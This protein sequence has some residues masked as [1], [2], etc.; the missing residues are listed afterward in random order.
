MCKLSDSFAGSVALSFSL[1]MGVYACSLALSTKKRHDPPD[2]VEST[3]TAEPVQVVEKKRNATPVNHSEPPKLI[4]RPTPKSMPSNVKNTVTEGAGL[5]AINCAPCHQADGAGLPGFAPS[6][7]NRDF[8]ALS[9]DALILE[10]VRKGRLGTAMAPRP[11][12][13]EETVRKIIAYMRSMTV[14]NAI[15]VKVDDSLKFSG[16]AEAGSEKYARYCSSCHGPAGEGYSVGVP[17]TGIGLPG[18]LQAVSD[19][20]ILQTLKLGRI[21]TPMQP[22]V[23]SRGLANLSVSDAHDIIAHLREL[24]KRNSPGATDPVSEKGDPARGKLSY[25]V[26]CMACHQSEGAGRV[27][28]AP[29]IRNRDFLAIATDDF[30]RTTIKKG[31]FGTA[32][33]GRPDLS[34]PVID[35]LI[36][37]LRSLPVANPVKMKVDHSLSFQGDS[38]KGLLKYN[39]YCASCHGPRGE[40]YAVGVPGPGIGLAGFLSTVSDDYILQTIRHGRVGTPMRS[41]IGAKGVANLS[42]EDAHDII[43]HLRVMGKESGTS[44]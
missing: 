3:R 13:S 30:I 27:G 2:P 40:G 35:D 33:V 23:G 44:Q 7:R 11:D 42:T 14:E 29:S 19:D 6:I 10:T 36:A 34:D 1:C 16:N 20:Y 26:N 18:F 32:M 21:G 24:G 39:S 22:F 17:G 43:A 8:L 5:F 41:F 38:K 37:Y 12:L 25:D 31:R 4:V 15:T 28:F 9:S